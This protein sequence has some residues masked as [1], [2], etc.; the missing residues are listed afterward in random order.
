MGGD[1]PLHDLFPCLYHLSQFKLH[2]VG[3]VLPSRDPLSS[4]SLG[5]SRHLTDRDV[6]EVA[7]LLV[8]LQD[9]LVVHGSC[10]SRFLAPDPSRGYSCSSYF[11]L[12]STSLISHSISA[13]SSLWK[14]EFFSSQVMHGR[15][16]TLDR[17][18]RHSS[19]CFYSDVY[20]RASLKISIIFCGTIVGFLWLELDVVWGLL[21]DD[22]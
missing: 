14:V 7:S 13:F 11:Y 5:F 19:S 1:K 15:V 8:L 21:C 3:G 6:L 17:V 16:N 9:S 10:D 2:F 12:W 20:A 4:I 18:Q 22:R